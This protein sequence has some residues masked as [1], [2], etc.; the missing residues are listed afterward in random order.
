MAPLHQPPAFTL[1]SSSATPRL[2]P[3][4]LCLCAWPSPCSLSPLASFPS[5]RNLPQKMPSCHE[6]CMCTVIVAALLR[7]FTLCRGALTQNISKATNCRHNHAGL[8]C[9][10]VTV[11]AI[12][13]LDKECV[14]DGRSGK[15]ALSYSLSLLPCGFVVC[16]FSVEVLMKV[17]YR[18]CLRAT[19]MCPRLHIFISVP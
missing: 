13:C 8:R 19:V 3:V 4:C 15:V 12:A 5:S 18:P 16:L 7:L 2:V 9:R 11:K 17:S 10:H 6:M 14:L 1:L